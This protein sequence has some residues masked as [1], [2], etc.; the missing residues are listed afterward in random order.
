MSAT[1]IGK[2][3]FMVSADANG[4]RTGLLVGEQAL[5]GFGARITSIYQSISAQLQLNPITQFLGWGVKLAAE[6][7]QAETGF[8]VFLGSA[9]QAKELLGEI[10][11]FSLESPLNSPDL[12]RAATTLLGY[13]VA[14]EQVMP[15]LRQLG[16]VSGGN[17]ERFNLLA[18][19]AAQVV[20]VGRLQGQELRQL[21]QSGFNPLKVIAD[22][23][24]LSM[25]EL[26]KKMEDGAISSD[27]FM[28]ALR[29]ATSE[30]G[31]FFG[32]IDEQS[33]TLTGRWENLKESAGALA[34]EVGEFVTPSLIK[35]IDTGKSVVEWFN[36]LDTTTIRNTANMV[37]MTAAFAATVTVIP[38]IVT[39]IMSI[40]SAL[41]AMAVAQSITEALTGPAGIAMVVAGIAAGGVAAL[42]VNQMFDDLETKLPK[43]SK[44]AKEA[45]TSVSSAF[46]ALT[47]ADPGEGLDALKD[48]LKGIKDEARDT[49]KR[50]DDM[51]RSVQSQRSNAFTSAADRFTTAGL[52]AISTSALERVIQ[53]EVRRLRA[54]QSAALKSLEAQEKATTEAIKAKEWNVK[55]ARI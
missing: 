32:M 43:V 21:T 15:I 18:I 25:A 50:F 19:A 42:A 3:N 31:Q 51:I 45:A 46:D 37:A 28:E 7:E 54:E 8:R 6:G 23:T 27:M 48:K 12:Q 2:L 39:G 10:R 52:Q 38:R 11:Q 33:Q 24:G 55:Q 14:G 17:A 4:V 36:E 22:Q 20:S 44:E 34:R 30:G 29:I 53:E 41:R 40:V 9:T 1:T 16:D 13:G 47:A 5:S 49:K 35:L 26:K